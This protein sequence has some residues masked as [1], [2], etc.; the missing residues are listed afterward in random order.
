MTNSIPSDNDS[1]LNF[2]SKE[3][4]K[5]LTSSPGVYRMHNE[6]GDVIYVG[7]AKNLKKRV[8]SYF[9][10]SD[11]TPK[12]RV[13]VAQIRSIEITVTHTENEALILESNLIKSLRPQ[14]NILYRDDKSYPYIY[15]SADKS[16]PRLSYYRGSR[17]EKGR[18]FGPYPSA[19]AARESLNLLQK[20]F[21]VRQCEDSFFKNRSR[22]CLQFQIKRCSAPCVD[23][24][25]PKEYAEEVKHAS[26]FLEGKNSEVIDELASKMEHEAEKLEYELA[27]KY[28]DQIAALSKVQER[29]YITSAGRKDIDVIAAAVGGGVACV[30]VFY[31]RGG[32]NL[33]NKS[34]FPKQAKDRS[35]EELLGAFAAQHYVG[36]QTGHTIPTEII[37]NEK[38]SDAELL[39]DVL[40]EQLGKKVVFSFN[41]RTERSHWL[42]LALN[43]A[44][45][46]LDTH[47]ANKANILSRFENLQD[48]LAL[49]NLPQRIEC[50]DISHTMGEETVASCVV[51][52]I[53]GML[54]SDYRRFNIKDIT[55]GD[56]YAAMRQALTRRYKRIQEGEGKLPDILLI[57]GA[58][59]QLTQAENVL[60]ELQVTGVIMIG[61]A[62][63]PDRKPGMETLWLSGNKQPFI[64]PP[65]SPALHLIQMVRDESH[66][67]AIQGH[68]ARRGK[69][70][71]TSILEEIPGL[72]PKRRQILLRQFGGL[73]GVSSA[74]V[75][76][77]ARI[78]GISKGLAQK[79]YDIF[80]Q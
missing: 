63:G 79:I 66:R 69:K 37:F 78:N 38:P 15:L 58:K 53:N 60:E 75:E 44:Q 8:A 54:K 14:Y 7:K 27:A 16:Y 73:Q 77:L 10:K 52:D 4:L 39:Q 17:K 36:K 45:N 71:E 1:P 41:V 61:V 23:L 59:G 65:N 20:L 9:T 70:R 80:H 46:A 48:V 47:L 31:F 49:E 74:G 25:T 13:M 30:Q 40:S 11:L 29:Q 26:M 21:P 28:R 34:F 12:T 72:G 24:I 33:G 56:D 3:F 50:F 68:R 51:S 5:N 32:N 18:F 42:Q 64:L 76:D 2:D 57:D 67:F 62:K 19:G 6:K 22:P 55:P 35:I 43:N